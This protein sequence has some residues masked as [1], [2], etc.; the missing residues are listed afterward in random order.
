AYFQELAGDI[1]S[2]VYLPAVQQIKPECLE[3]MRY[4]YFN[5]P[6]RT[7]IRLLDK[8]GILRFI[9]P[10]EDWREELIGKDYSKEDFFQEAKETGRIGVFG[11]VINEQGEAR[12]RIAFPIYLIY[13]KETLVDHI[14]PESGRFQGILVGSFD[15]YI[16]A[17]EFTSTIVSGKTGY[18]WVLNEEGIFLAHHEEGF[19][20]WNA[21]EVRTENNPEISYETIEHIQRKMMAGEE[22]IGHYISGCHRGEKGKFEN[23]IAYT[24]IRF[25]KHIW[26]VAV[27]AP[28]SEVE[29]IIHKSQRSERYTLAF[30]ILA[31]ITGGL[32]LLI[33]SYRWS[34]SLEMEVARRT[35]EL[36]ETSDYLNN[37]INYANAPIIVWDPGFRITRFNHAFEHLTGYTANEVID[38]ELSILFPE[39]SRDESLRKIERT[40]TGEYWESVEIPILRKDGDI[41]VALWNSANIYGD[42]K[43][44]IAT[45]A[46]G[47]DITERRQAEET[48]KQSEEKLRSIL[49]SMPD[50]CY[51]V[52]KDYKIEFMNKALMERF[53]E[54]TGDICYKAFFNRETP[55]PWTKLEDIQKGK[56]VR[57]EHYSS[58]LKGTFDIIDSPLKNK[59]GTISK[60]GIWRDISERKQAEEQIKTSLKEKEVLLREI[61]HRVKNNLQVISSLL[62]IQVRA[63][64]DKDTIEILSESINRINAMS[65]IHTQLYESEDLSAINMKEFVDRLLKQL[66]QS[67]SVPGT[68]I[69][70]ETNLVE[71]PFPISIAVP[72]GLIINELLT[73]VLKHAFHKRKKGKI[74]VKLNASEKGKISLTVSDDG[75]GL[76]KEFDINVSKTLGLH[77]VKILVE[78]QLQGNLKI[79]GK[80]GTTFKIEFEVGND[81]PR[82][83]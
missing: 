60:L 53:G 69:T 43:T 71:Y 47:I 10:S 34:H 21:F 65:L 48:L 38:K 22:G 18:A 8:N 73:N 30:V 49:N 44:V 14:G 77:L 57:W 58:K 23:I 19:T 75:A 61:H 9:Y 66:L 55:C 80:K 28:V 62:K 37:L 46:Q 20:G 15:P 17:K 39:A 4:A 79:I 3:Y 70:H 36:K 50:Y 81:K 27:C 31:L 12:L 52:S 76:P 51:I 6:S 16:I 32:S 63:T 72:I 59:D 5:F 56:T 54:H 24:P 42:G 2:L 45:I 33:I 1:S 7:S 40:L 25:D 68:K 29:N 74:G 13:K 82:G 64:K 41:R 67:Y 83:G 35:R 26:G 11:M 78:D